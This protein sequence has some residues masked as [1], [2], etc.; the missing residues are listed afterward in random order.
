MA[1]V[2]Y[3]IRFSKTGPLRW[4][5]HRD[6]IR[7][8]ERLLR[9]ARLDLS[10]SEGFHPKPRMSFP[11]ALAL[12]TESLD[13]VIELELVDRIP[14]EEL[15]KRL[16]DDGQP[17]LGILVAQAVPPGIGKARL[18]TT[19]YNF[20]IPAD[21]ASDLPERIDRLLATETIEVTRKEKTKTFKVAEE[22][23]SLSRESDGLEMTLSASQQGALK[24]S[25]IIEILGLDHLVDSG[26]YLT[27]TRVELENEFET[28]NCVTEN[29][30]S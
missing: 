29:H 16:R 17:G 30:A 13:E 3:R 4:I 1:G 12:G 18:R 5:S 7:L 27:R 24:A 11:S 10:M 8:W 6:L 22:I 2:R 9:R 14:D 28:N 19:S 20:P 23:L 15:L 25:D 26:G 21:A